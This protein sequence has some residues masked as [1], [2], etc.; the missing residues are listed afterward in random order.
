LSSPENA[1]INDFIDSNL[2]SVQYARFDDAVHM[3]HDL[4]RNCKLFKMDLK[5]AFRLLPVRLADIELLGFQFMNRYYVD[6][7]MPMG[8]LAVDILKHLRPSWSLTSKVKCQ[9]VV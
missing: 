8:C 1:S 2:C 6:K 4:G 3:I 5:N 7:A 9:L